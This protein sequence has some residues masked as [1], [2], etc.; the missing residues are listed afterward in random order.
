MA[1]IGIKVEDKR[2]Y[3]RS[4]YV[5]RAD[6]AG[7]IDTGDLVERRGE[8]FYFIGRAENTMIN[9]GGQKAFPPDIEAHL[10]THPEVL[11]ARV[12]ARKAPLVGALPVA[13]VVLKSPTDQNEAEQMLN[14]HCE[15]GLAEYAV[16]RLWELHDQ[17]P[18]QASLKS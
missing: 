4:P 11:W 15:A 13:E 7:W 10:M 5:N 14:A 12:T 18:M 6:A 2:L 3:I 1:P 16:P 8:R 9:V 17:I